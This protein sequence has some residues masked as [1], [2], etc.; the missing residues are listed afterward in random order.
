MEKTKKNFA[1][2]IGEI[3][4]YPNVSNSYY[5]D[6]SYIA[7]QSADLNK[8]YK[9]LMKYKEI[10]QEDLESTVT[11]KNPHGEDSEFSGLEVLKMV[12]AGDFNSQYKK[13][14]SQCLYYQTCLSVWDAMM[15]SIGKK[16]TLKLWQDKEEEN[17]SKPRQYTTGE[18]ESDDQFQKRILS[19]RSLLDEV[20]GV[21]R[22]DDFK[23]GDP[24]DKENKSLVYAKTI[25]SKFKHIEEFN[26]EVKG[27]SYATIEKSIANAENEEEKKKIEQ[28]T[29]EAALNVANLQ[30]TKIVTIEDYYLRKAA[31]SAFL[32]GSSD[33]PYFNKVLKS[34]PTIKEK[35]LDKTSEEEIIL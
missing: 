6:E 3:V 4:I 28:R 5:N 8:A 7:C 33:D 17:K 35:I 18:R 25:C 23:T 19:Q 13:T 29:N 16:E 2:E 10:T 30:P 20:I 26:K 31:I 24:L 34:I 22:W 11:K 21:M 9:A 12:L 32:T 1:E 27:H 14:S 15:Q